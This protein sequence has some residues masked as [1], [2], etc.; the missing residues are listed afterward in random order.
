MYIDQRCLGTH[1]VRPESGSDRDARKIMRLLKVS[2]KVSHVL[3]SSL[4][5]VYL[6]SE[7]FAVR[8][9]SNFVSFYLPSSH[10]A[11]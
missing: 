11:S 6:L 2:I 3:K 4:S 1:F 5:Y 10:C 7:F 8:S 9:N